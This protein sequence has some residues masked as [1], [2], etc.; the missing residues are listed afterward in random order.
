MDNAVYPSD[1]ASQI[2]NAQERDE[3]FKDVLTEENPNPE[4]D[5]SQE[6]QAE[7]ASR[8]RDNVVSYMN[9]CDKLKKLLSATRN[10]RKERKQL[11]RSLITD[12]N[13]LDVENLKLREGQLVARRSTPKVPLTKSSVISALT[14]NLQDSEM[15][16]T[17]MD[18]L[19]NKRD[20]YEKVELAH[21]S[22]KQK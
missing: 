19:Y 9:T 15:V 2:Q 14:K 13:L 18:I 22:K 6:T 1:S 4:E 10:L 3:R 11:E 12:M 20:R 21:Y 16:D 5:Q 17:I 8:L 7:I